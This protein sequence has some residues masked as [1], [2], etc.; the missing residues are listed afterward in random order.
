ME[1][2]KIDKRKINIKYNWFNIRRDFIEGIE[3]EEGHYW[4]TMKDLSDKYNIPFAYLRQIAAEQKWKFEQDS[5]ITTFEHAIQK[6][7][8]QHLTKR[9]IKFDNKCAS[10]A[11]KGISQIEQLLNFANNHINLVNKGN[12]EFE[13]SDMNG[14]EMEDPKK[15]S[16]EMIISLD[17]LEQAAKILVNFQKI[18]RVAFG[19]AATINKEE[20]TITMKKAVSFSEGLAKVAQHIKS[21]PLFKDKI[22]K[23]FIDK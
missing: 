5:F 10:I 2:R 17:F 9:I 23:E 1:N 8:I 20:N 22:E 4:P 19:S 21:N 11:E 16:K 12:D 7:K 3:N 6:K 18:G 15:R 13:I 14:S